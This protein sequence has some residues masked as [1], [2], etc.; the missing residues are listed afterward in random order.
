MN[1]RTTTI[2]SILIGA[3]ALAGCQSVRFGGGSVAS[4]PPPLPPAPSAPVAQSTLPPLN[5]TTTDIAGQTAPDGSEQVAAI[6]STPPPATGVEVGRT[7][8]LGGWTISGAGDNCQLFMS[9]TSWAG[10]YRATTRGC[11]TP[12]LQGVSAWNLENNRVTL[13]DDSGGQVAQLSATSKTQFSGGGVN[14][15]R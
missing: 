7:D 2:L 1:F 3:L 14:F 6:A 12:T 13:L 5:E 10:G 8:L 11:A 15:Y 9:L 4:A